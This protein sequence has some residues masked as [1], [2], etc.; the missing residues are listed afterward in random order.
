MIAEKL[1]LNFF[2]T[3]AQSILLFF[4]N[5]FIIFF[6][7]EKLRQFLSFKRFSNWKQ[8]IDLL[9][10]KLDGKKSHPKKL[11]WIHVA[12]AGELEQII[13][14]L[15]NLS[16]NYS[17]HFFLTYFSPSTIPFIEKAPA[18]VHHS[19]FPVDSKKFFQYALSHIAF[20]GLVLV[21][22]DVWPNFLSC[23]ETQKIPI[24]LTCATARKTKKGFFR[25]L[26][27]VYTKFVYKKIDAVFSVERTDADYF[28][29][30][31]TKA[32]IETSGDTKW[33]RALERSSKIYEKLQNNSFDAESLNSKSGFNFGGARKIFE[34]LAFKRVI[35][36]ASPHEDEFKVLEKLLSSVEK[37]YGFFICAPHSISQQSLSKFI[38]LPKTILLSEALKKLSHFQS[39]TEFFDNFVSKSCLIID[40]MGVLAELFSLSSFAKTHQYDFELKSFSPPMCVVGGGFDGQ[41]HNVLEPAAARNIVLTGSNLYRAAEAL[42]LSKS[43]A[44]LTFETPAELFHFLEQWITLSEVPRGFEIHEVLQKSKLLFATAS[45]SVELVSTKIAQ[46]V[47]QTH[48]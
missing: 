11:L 23:F 33:F 19:G 37:N 13:P 3:S 6:H 35:F 5:R 47:N 31:C 45:A 29:K 39:S 46:R 44:S 18:V 25:I 4:A 36:F 17:C 8:Q 42:Q 28:K 12:S 32:D 14:V 9:A 48:E 27:H 24:F 26:S 34:Y 2:W 38:R 22:Y 30:Y 43:G 7:S 10:E 41:V 21:R 20:S 40:T 15:T 16:E 1:V